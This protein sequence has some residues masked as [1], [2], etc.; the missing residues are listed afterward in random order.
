MT[1]IILLHP[2][3]EINPKNILKSL[4]SPYLVGYGLLH[5]ASYLKKHNYNVEVWNVPMAYAYGFSLD[6]ICAL[7][8]HKLPFVIGIELNWLHFSSGAISLAKLIK[9]INPNIK[10]CFG[11]VHSTIF[12]ET[13]IKTYSEIDAVFIGEA[14][15]SFLKYIQAIE[16]SQIPEDIPSSIVR[17]DG[18]FVK[19][20]K[21]V[22]LPIDE[23]PPY[24]LSL[25]KPRQKESFNI[26]TINTC[27]GPCTGKCPYCIG[28]H[29][30]YML[31]LGSRKLLTLHS[32]EWILQQIKLLLKDT[33]NLAIQ[34][35][36]YC[37][38]K[39]RI[40]EIFNLLK[41]EKIADYI[42]YFNIAAKPNSFDKEMLELMSNAG[43]DNIDYGIETG[44][45]EVLQ[46]LRRGYTYHQVCDSIKTTVKIGIFPKTFWM[47][48]LPK[49]NLSMT[50]SLIKDTINLGAFPRWVTPLI[51][52]PQTEL[53]RNPESFNITILK[54]T[55]QDFL[56]FSTTHLNKKSYYPNLITHTTSNMDVHEILAAA[57][58]LKDYIMSFKPLIMDLFQKNMLNTFHFHDTIKKPLIINRMSFVLDTLKNTLF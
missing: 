20:E 16:K 4:M 50:K 11:G 35:Y 1:D 41:Q 30:N 13:L 29:D 45:D 49:E 46:I 54:K 39:K 47:V 9:K 15:L 24:S 40:M 58:E 2:P 23:I 26:G 19:N 52:L 7:I 5:I 42:E 32:P 57:N 55:F 34:D 17:I 31:M 22:V 10:V 6:D 44:S 28:A 8:K 33:R 53:S 14:E 25:I 43:I 38:P 36:I 56:D 51:I 12:A 21:K 3:P 37:A 18:K 48:G 27:R